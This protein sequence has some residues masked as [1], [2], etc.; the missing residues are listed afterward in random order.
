MKHERLGLY[1]ILSSVVL[2]IIGF[3]AQDFT[4]YVYS[5]Q[6]YLM[7][8]SRPLYPLGVALLLVSV[9]TFTLSFYLVV[10]EKV[11]R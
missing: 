4:Q 9:V 3:L 10:K 5:S 1:L 2:V 6:G 8:V 7:G 11:H